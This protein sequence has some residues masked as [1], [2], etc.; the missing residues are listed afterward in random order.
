MK[1]PP[2]NA[3]GVGMTHGQLFFDG[4]GLFIARLRGLAWVIFF[5]ILHDYLPFSWMDYNYSVCC[6]KPARRQAFAVKRADIHRRNP[7]H[8]RHTFSC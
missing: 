6:L 3:G 5:N 1:K 7:Y 4:L 2:A 8:T